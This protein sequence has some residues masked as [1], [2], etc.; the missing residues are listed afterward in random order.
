[1][2]H[3]HIPGGNVNSTLATYR[4]KELQ[5]MIDRGAKLNEVLAAIT[6]YRG[7]EPTDNNNKI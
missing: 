2:K 7:K 3:V 4:A 6:D 1:M 5:E